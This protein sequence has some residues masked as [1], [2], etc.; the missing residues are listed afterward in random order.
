MALALAL[1]MAKIILG[2]PMWY[3]IVPGYILA[4]ILM[5]FSQANFVSIAFDAG[6]VATG[7]M[8]AIT[9]A[10]IMIGITSVMAG[11]DPVTDS[12]GLVALMVMAPIVSVL[13]LGV[14]FAR[15]SG[16]QKEDK[17]NGRT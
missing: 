14:F 8:P 16:K 15:A 13:A 2:I 4:L 5:R 1:G 6:G 12:F 3:I 9:A 10:A 7:P 11:R 17:S